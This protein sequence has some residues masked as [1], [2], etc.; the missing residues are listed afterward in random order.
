MVTATRLAWRVAGF[1]A[2]GA[3]AA[4]AVALS[5]HGP[6]SMNLVS[7][8]GSTTLPACARSAVQI[9]ALA[10]RLE[11]TNS[12]AMSCELTGYPATELPGAV[13]GGRLA[14]PV[15][16]VTLRRGTSAYAR[17]EVSD[18][19]CRHPAMIGVL[20]VRLPGDQAYS[21]IGYRAHAC[22][23]WVGAF[24]SAWPPGSSGG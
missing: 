14:S 21:Y 11:F 10:D 5:S 3:T 16:M 8:G 15:V 17:L 7:V 13:A 19:G 4:L 20:G 12:A 1:A 6:A 9:T 22:S 18:R 23:V 24:R 2:F